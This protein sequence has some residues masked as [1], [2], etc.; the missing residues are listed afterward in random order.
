MKDGHQSVYNFFVFL[1][2][3]FTTPSVV[4]LKAQIVIIEVKLK[5]SGLNTIFSPK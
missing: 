2:L 3:L 1:V 4:V 5:M